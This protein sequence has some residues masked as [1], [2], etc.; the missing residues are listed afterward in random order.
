MPK[1]KASAESVADLVALVMSGHVRIPV[2]QRGFKWGAADV[3]ALFESIYLGYPVGSLLFHRGP[4]QARMIEVGPIKVRA[5][6]TSGALWVVDGQQ[7]LAALSASLARPE[8]IP[9]APTDPFVVYF[10]PTTRTF[11]APP[12]DGEIPATWVPVPQLLD[13]S[14]LTEWVF[15]W[16]HGRDQALRRAVFEAGARIREYTIPAYTVE[17]EDEGVLREIFHRVNKYG[18]R[19]DWQEVHDALLGAR[20]GPIHPSTLDELA[21]ELVTVGI[22]RPHEQ[23]QLLRCLVAFEGLDVTRSFDEH[24]RNEPEFLA[25]TAGAALP[26][27]RRV[28]DFLSSQAG[29]IHLRLLPRSAPLTVLTRFFRLHPEPS[30]RSLQ[31]LRRWLWRSILGAR[32]YDERTFQRRG[33][34]DIDENEEA[35]V[36]RLLQFL[37]KQQPL[38][39]LPARFD[40]RAADSR[41]AMLSLTALAPRDPSTGQA[42]EPAGVIDDGSIDAFR[43]IVRD[44]PS[45]SSP[46]NRVILPGRGLAK[47]ELLHALEHPLSDQILRSHAISPPAAEA[48]A[49]GAHELFL[50]E[51][52]HTLEAQIAELGA[53]MAEWTA[54]DRPSIDYLI[55]QV[56]VEHGPT[57]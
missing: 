27:L 9:T 52:K 51:R 34:S 35:S 38:F 57:V 41:L 13:P 42:I 26:T 2:F 12:P 55:A 36:Q 7:R 56:E 33:V 22:G 10:D 20:A 14:K 17:T 16:P 6:E 4:A 5:P 48:L 3:V 29:I 47:D 28:F 44:G 23:D 24:Y 50:A 25:G 40:A 43:R 1:P 53:T 54:N 15:N 18:K 11:S 19:L 31:L 30:T 32:D 45:A 46:A 8:P 37:P 21:D 49:A 39:E